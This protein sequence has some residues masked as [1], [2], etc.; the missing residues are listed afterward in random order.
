MPIDEFGGAVAV[1]TGGASGI[2]LA[3]AKALYARG[4][5]VAL[6]DIN[7]AALAG[8]AEQV[9]ASA[10]SVNA[11]VITVKTDVTDDAQT[12]N[13]IAEAI[14]LTGR[15]DLLV[16][17]AGIGRGGSIESLSSAAMRQMLDVNVMGVYNSVQA[18][19]PVMKA[20][21]SGHMTLISSVAG[22]L[23]A[24]ALSGYCASKWAVRGFSIA[25]RAE[26]Y[27]TN[28][29][30]TTVY[31]AWVDTPMFQQEAAQAEGLTIEV[32][33]TPEQVADA[34][35]QAAHDG[36]RDLTL[37]PNPDIAMLIERTRDDPDRAE[38]GAGRAYYRRLHP[39][40]S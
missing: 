22:K 35:V 11:Q 40:Q 18:A 34:I 15:V 21:G 8:A 10:P 7:D 3:T 19:V 31:P 30:V 4:A 5:H 27:G 14:K 39:Q 36:T 12:R 38:D 23:G 6:A 32:M 25:L 37:T 17:C 2:G 16:A 20:Q 29:T 26:L 9:R 13:M 24:P 33:L 28:I 1:I